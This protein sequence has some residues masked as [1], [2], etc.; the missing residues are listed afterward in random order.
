MRIARG[1]GLI[2]RRPGSGWQP[3]ARDYRNQETCL[4]HGIEQRAR[5]ICLAI[6][7]LANASRKK[8]EGGCR[9]MKPGAAANSSLGDQR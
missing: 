2:H 1:Q 7:H 4:L 9:R 8:A 3:I 5:Q 6:H